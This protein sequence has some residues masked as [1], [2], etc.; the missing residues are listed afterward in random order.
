MQTY[1]IYM[2]K[3]KKKDLSF[4]PQ[5]PPCDGTLALERLGLSVVGEAIPSQSLL[6]ALEEAGRA[7]HVG[8]VE[9]LLFL[10]MDSLQ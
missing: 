6:A 8:V 10:Q 3:K 5:N 9:Q 1:E 7:A 2:Q 4:T